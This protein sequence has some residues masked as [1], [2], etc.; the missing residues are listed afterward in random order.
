MLQAVL[1]RKFVALSIIA[2]LGVT[3]FLLARSLQESTRIQHGV[4][5][6]REPV[7]AIMYGALN[8]QRPDNNPATI[9][10]RKTYRQAYKDLKCDNGPI[11]GDTK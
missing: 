7:C 9:E 3:G 5:S 1:R 6:V 2:V 4:D 11:L 10:S 8:R